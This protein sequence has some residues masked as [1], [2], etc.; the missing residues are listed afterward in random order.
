MTRPLQNGCLSIKRR[1]QLPRDV[2]AQARSMAVPAGR[3]AFPTW[4]EIGPSSTR[5]L[6]IIYLQEPSKTPLYSCLLDRP[7]AGM[8]NFLVRA[9]NYSGITVAQAEHNSPLKGPSENIF[10]FFF[11]RSF[12]CGHGHTQSSYNYMICLSSKKF[13]TFVES[14]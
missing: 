4:L 8:P 5:G 9:N 13:S 6:T 2:T 12:L 10:F 14:A 1:A 7:A 3:D 11:Y